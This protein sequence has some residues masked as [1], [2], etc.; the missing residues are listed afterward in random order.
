MKYFDENLVGK[1]KKVRDMY[2]AIYFIV[3]MVYVLFSVGCVLWFCTLPYKSPKITTVKL[4]HYPVTFAFIVFSFIFLFIPVKRS[5]RFYK[6]VFN[7]A[8]G[9]RETSIAG[10]F[11]VDHSIQDKDGVDMKALIFLEWNKYKEEY[12]ERKVLVFADQPVPIIPETARVK[13][14][15]QGNVLIEYDIVEYPDQ[16]E[17]NAEEK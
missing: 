11:E 9:L 15:T 6:L 8:N 17:N 16:I 14:I 5:N 3:A 12:Y 7:M 13:F 2:R 1:A 4:V 10:F